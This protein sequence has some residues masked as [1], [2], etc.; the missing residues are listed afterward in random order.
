MSKTIDPR[1]LG[2]VARLYG[3]K[4]AEK[5]L[6]S[7]VMVV[8]LGGVG[9][10]VV[11]ALARTGTGRL[12]L[13]DG[14][15]VALSNTNRQLHALEGNYGKSKAAAMK[16]RV[17]QINPDAEVEIIEEFVGTENADE[18]VSRRPDWIIDCID[19]INAKAALISAAKRSG[20]AIAVSGGAGGK[21]RP[22]C[23]ESSDLALSQGDPLLAK[24]RTILRKT[25]GFPK[26]GAKAGSSRKFGVPAVFSTEPLKQP[27][28][29]NKEAIGAGHAE[30]IGFGSGIV[31]TASVGLRLA[32]IVI[33]SIVESERQADL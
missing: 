16:E 25:Y 32:S 29:E 21:L 28:V 1:R 7:H 11:E 3:E 31:V 10:W 12:T 24:T 13:V 2:G 5:L 27:T 26:G 19:S 9:S 8:G 22:E 14:D 20:V 15:E 4:G 33:N 30:M 23:I 18:I 6:D 17:L